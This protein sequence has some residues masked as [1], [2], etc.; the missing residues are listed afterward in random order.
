MKTGNTQLAMVNSKKDAKD[1]IEHLSLTIA[2]H[3]AYIVFF[4]SKD[5]E[6][7][8]RKEISARFYTIWGLKK[9]RTSKGVINLTEKELEDFIYDTIWMGDSVR[10]LEDFYRMSVAHNKKLK[11]S[12]TKDELEGLEFRLVVLIHDLYK[13]MIKSVLG[14]TFT[15]VEI[16]DLLKVFQHKVEDLL[17]KIK[18]LS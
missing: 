10:T 17:E 14:N 15:R 5:N 12:F 1:R 4:H 8:W 3:I 2:E 9:V 7:H 18:P 13:D 11:A 16:E 6:K